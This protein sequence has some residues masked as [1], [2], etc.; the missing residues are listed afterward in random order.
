MIHFMCMYVCTFVCTRRPYYKPDSGSMET[1]MGTPEV[2]EEAGLRSGLLRGM[3]QRSFFE[4]EYSIGRRE[5]RRE[6]GEGGR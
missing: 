6:G 1:G 5:V 4:D 2:P 3:R